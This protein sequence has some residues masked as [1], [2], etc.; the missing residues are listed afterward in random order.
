VQIAGGYGVV[1]N[2]GTI[3]ATAS[4]VSYKFNGGIGVEATAGGRIDNGVSGVGSALISGVAF[5]VLVSGGPG[6]VI[7]AGT[8]TSAYRGVEL[9]GGPDTVINSGTITGG[10]VG[11]FFGLEDGSA[12]LTNTG[13]ISGS[14]ADRVTAVVLDAGSNTLA[15]GAGAVFHGTVDAN[16][17][18]INTLQLLAGPAGT[19]SGIGS[20]YLGFQTLAVVAGA[21]WSVAGVNAAGADFGVALRAD[22]SLE[23]TGSLNVGSVLT[24]QGRGTLGVAAAGQLVVGGTAGAAGVVTVEREIVGSGTIAT[25]IADS[26]SIV[27]SGGT[28]TLGSDT[29]GTGTVAISA[30]SVLQADAGLSTARVEF[31]LGSGEKLALAEPK[32]MSSQIIGF[33]RGDRIDLLGTV[34]TS[35]SFSSATDILTVRGAGGAIAALRFSSSY[36]ALRFQLASD[37]HGGS[38]ILLN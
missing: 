14:G 36:G 31:L 8:I 33:A 19:V 22:A 38:N 27:A 29:G 30:H 7:N 9:F 20:E 35:L 13:T 34:A 11:V 1:H 2:D 15:I 37:G 18:G 26:G 17:Q 23:V 5:G 12:K 6:I 21:Y 4:Y 28:L 10:D 16:P 3:I 24:L 32:R 25:S